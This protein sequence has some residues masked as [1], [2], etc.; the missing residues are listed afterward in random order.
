MATCPERQGRAE[1]S[2]PGQSRRYVV[3]ADGEEINVELQLSESGD[4][5][6]TVGD[7]AGEAQV[8]SAHHGSALLFK[9]DGNVLAARVASTNENFHITTRDFDF[10]CQVFSESRFLSAR[11]QGQGGS[12][13]GSVVAQMPGRVVRLMVSEG[14]RVEKGQGVLCL[15]AMKM[16]N[17]VRAGIS[18]VVKTIRVAEGADVEAGAIMLEIGDG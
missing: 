9:S 7:N 10:S 3:I 11:I 14:D 12:A 15:E 1:L 8:G 5:H 16:E 18:G 6:Y 4:L 17:E 13:Q 2:T